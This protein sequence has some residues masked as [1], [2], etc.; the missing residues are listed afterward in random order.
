MEIQIKLWRCCHRNSNVPIGFLYTFLT[1][2][3]LTIL[4]VLFPFLSYLVLGLDSLQ[5]SLIGYDLGA[6]VATGFAAKYPS[7]CASLVLV[8]PIGIHYEPVAEDSYLFKKYFGEYLM[9]NGKRKLI[10]AQLDDFYQKGD[11]SPAKPLID[12]Q[13]NMVKWQ[14]NNT[15][16]Y[17]GSL[18]STYRLFPLRGMEELYT[19]VGRHPRAVMVIWGDQD[20]VC[21]YRPCIHQ[22]ERSF[23]SAPI[24]DIKNAGHNC[25]FEKFDEVVTEI[26]CF[27]KELYNLEEEE[28]ENGTH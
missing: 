3:S 24:V 22:M 26:L 28:D 4:Y 2:S 14:I 13:T 9:A 11:R 18:L 19:A 27:H 1:T 12:K 16:G 20:E 6:A 7:L 8:S 25:I 21:T 17:L 15:A 10:D 23:P 5:V